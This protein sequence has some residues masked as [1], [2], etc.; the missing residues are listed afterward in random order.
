MS[1][2]FDNTS[3]PYPVGADGTLT[4]E[5]LAERQAEFDARVVR[6]DYM[7]HRGER[8]LREV[9]PTG[10]RF[11]ESEHHPGRQWLLEV[12]DVGK[13]APR[14]YALSGLTGWTPSREV[15]AAD[16]AYDAFQEA[17]PRG[18][19]TAVPQK[20]NMLA[21]VFDDDGNSVADLDYTDDP[22]VA[23]SY[24]QLFAGAPGLY[25]A[26][27]AVV[28]KLDY[29]CNLWGSEGVTRTLRDGLVSAMERCTPRPL[30]K[31]EE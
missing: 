31:P 29:L 12:W 16:S 13:N 18:E 1:E 21:Q 2:S 6:L 27:R 23:S 26:C 14:T 10:L 19:L 5:Q 15:I 28:R 11:G 8:A 25:L 24:A 22:A 20:S 30:P 3:P 17:F 4:P 9:Y 7:N